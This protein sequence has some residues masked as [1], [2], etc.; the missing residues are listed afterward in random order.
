M[1]RGGGE[2]MGQQATRQ[3]ALELRAS[4]ILRA[5]R[6]SIACSRLSRD[7][8]GLFEAMRCMGRVTRCTKRA[9]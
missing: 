8:R 4:L 3:R 1:P 6:D 9:C 2:A 7:E 5:D